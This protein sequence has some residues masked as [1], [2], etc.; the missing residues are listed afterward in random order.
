MGDA[1]VETF[2]LVD[3]HIF[4]VTLSGADAELDTSSPL[5]MQQSTI[6]SLDESTWDLAPYLAL[7]AASSFDGPVGFLNFKLEDPADY[8][9]RS[10]EE[11]TT[12]CDEVGLYE[13]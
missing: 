4:A 3:D 9:A 13:P 2:A 5:A 8:L 1:L 10:I 12:L 11:W 7:I 6:M